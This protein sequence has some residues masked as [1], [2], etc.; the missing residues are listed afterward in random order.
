[1]NR[2]A[3]VADHSTACESPAL[4]PSLV[5]PAVL[6]VILPSSLISYREWA[7]RIFIFDPI[8]FPLA[9]GLLWP[10]LLAMQT[11]R[12]RSADPALSQHFWVAPIVFVVSAGRSTPFIIL[13]YRSFIR[14]RDYACAE[15]LRLQQVHAQVD[16]EKQQALEVIRATVSPRSPSR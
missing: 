1:M 4:W 2:T 3:H 6:A 10:V 12:I 5:I 8:Y 14:H 13:E 11:V 16:M 9:F 7:L 15:T